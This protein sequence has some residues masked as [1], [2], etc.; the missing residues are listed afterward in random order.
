MPPSQDTLSPLVSDKAF[1]HEE[2]E[3]S[4]LPPS[5]VTLV[6]QR[7]KLRVISPAWYRN[8]LLASVG[9]LE[10]ANAGDFAANVWNDVPVP[11]Y[12]VIF[13]AIGGPL[14][15]L[16]SVAALWDGILSWRNVR[17]LQ[18]ERQYL[19]ALRLQYLNLP[20]SVPVDQAS[21][22]LIDRRLGVSF[23]ELG[24]ELIDRVV[25]D[26]FL[27]IGALLVG[28]GTIMAI[29]G[30]H[31]H[32]YYISNLLSGFV[33]NSFAAAYGVLNAVWSL[34]LIWRFYGHDRA[35]TRSS[36]IT[37]FRDRLHRRF[38]YFQL[39]SLVSGITGLVAG[40][41]SM[42]TCK[43]WWGYVM[44][45]PCMIFEVGCNQFWR[46]QLGYDRPI[47]T[48]QPHWGL[49]PDFKASKEDDEEKDSVLLDTLASVI[50][51]QNALGPHPTAMIDVDWSSLDSLL[52][53]IVHNHLFDSLCGWLATHSSVPK[54]FH[55]NLFRFCADYT[56]ITLTLADLRNLPEVEHPRL[57]DLVRNF[58]YTEGRQV[59]I[60]RE[61]YLLEMVGY[62]AWKNC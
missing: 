13:M 32:I 36:A 46:V 55:Y 48:E 42:L 50:A 60:G 27:G 33:G 61:R 44:L 52:S 2:H 23:R 21:V 47:V 6:R 25:M 40:A 19:H 15:L 30:A 35:C 4:D 17:I 51:M 43:R 58:L 31:R 54:D 29:W 9:F 11:L 62:T 39:H 5:R 41:A 18:Q 20:P 10:F 14:A 16:I 56:E 45:I 28:T 7:R 49:I 12:A 1:H 8:S 57:L 37:P 53:F 38:Q 22:R 59:M 3:K 34:Y 24:S 26:V